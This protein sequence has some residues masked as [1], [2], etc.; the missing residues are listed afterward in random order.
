LILV[1]ACLNQGC[2]SAHSTRQIS[3]ELQKNRVKDSTF[4]EVMERLIE[5]DPDEMAGLFA[6]MFQFVMV[7]VRERLLRADQ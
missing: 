7:A 6:R 2:P 1:Q 4:E 5:H 3:R